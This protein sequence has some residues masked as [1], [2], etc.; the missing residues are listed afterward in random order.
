MPQDY[1][2][3]AKPRPKNPRGAAKKASPKNKASASASIN[4]IAV[5]ATVV[6]LCLVAGFV[7]FLN[8]VSG[9][10]DESTPVEMQS[11][12]TEAEE[13]VLP[14]P[15]EKRWDYPDDLADPDEV[16]VKEFEVEQ[17][18]PYQMQCGSFRTQAQADSLRAKIAFV[19]IESDVRRVEGTNGVWYKVV[20]GPYE[21]KRLAESDRHKLKNNGMNHC[22]IWLWT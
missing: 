14:P 18:G 4:P 22:R 11:P 17:K 15:P 3:R 21:R 12:Q 5:L 9:R 7:Y 13:T 10:G 8:Q 16:T 19:G 6:T 2:K 1:I 20:L